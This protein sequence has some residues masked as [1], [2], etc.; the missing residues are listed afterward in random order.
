MLPNNLRGRG[1]GRG[2][3]PVG[4]T[5]PHGTPEPHPHAS[6]D[7][8]SGPSHPTSPLPPEFLDYIEAMGQNIVQM[9]AQMDE[10]RGEMNAMNQRGSDSQHV[11]DTLHAELNDYKRDFIY[12][13]MKPLLRPLLF[14]Y[15]SLESFDREMESYELAQAGQELPDDALHGTKV[16]QNIT[17]LRDQLVQALSVGDVEPMPTPTV[18]HPFDAKTQKAVDTVAVEPALD[19]TVAQVVRIGWFMNGHI[20]RPA[21]IVLGKSQHHATNHPTSHSSNGGFSS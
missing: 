14:L 15:D 7:A 10:M 1:L 20:L 3:P 17:F 16:R 8:T 21:E 13:H 2:A 5:T 9:R 19:G 4:A 18:G 11:F 12:E 6:H